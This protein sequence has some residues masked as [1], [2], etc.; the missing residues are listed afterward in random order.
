[1]RITFD[2]AT[3]ALSI[4]RDDQPYGGDIVAALER[5]GQTISLKGSSFGVTIHADGETVLNAIWPPAGTHFVKTDQDVLTT[6]RASW[7]P[8]QAITVDA[9][10]ITTSGGRVDAHDSFT[11]PRPPRPFPSWVWD[12]GWRAPVPYPDDGVWQWDEEAGDWVEIEET[13]GPQ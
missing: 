3:N 11:A 5:H 6:T 8:D 7:Q 1:M 2:T 4:Q 9:W 13:E 12:G 10:C